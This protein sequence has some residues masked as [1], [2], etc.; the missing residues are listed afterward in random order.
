MAEYIDMFSPGEQH[1]VVWA[2]TLV[3]QVRHMDSNNQNK[4]PD[5]LIV[6][7]QG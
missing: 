3:F 7:S 1:Q 2:M 4:S 6:L 5:N